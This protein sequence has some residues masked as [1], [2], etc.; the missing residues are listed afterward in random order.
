[1]N[2]CFDS[3]YQIRPVICINFSM[4]LWDRKYKLLYLQVHIKPHILRNMY[5]KLPIYFLGYQLQEA[6]NYQSSE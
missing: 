3:I 4:P 6:G 1:M 2:K 5:K